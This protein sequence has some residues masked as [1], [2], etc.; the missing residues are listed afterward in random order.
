MWTTIIINTFAGIS[1]L[2]QFPQFIH[3]YSIRFVYFHC[4]CV[5][6]FIIIYCYCDSFLCVLCCVCFVRKKLFFPTSSWLLATTIQ[7]GNIE[8]KTPSYYK[9]I[10]GSNNNASLILWDDFFGRNVGARTMRKW[11][12]MGSQ[13]F[14][15]IAS[16][17]DGSKKLLLT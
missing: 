9:Q 1:K 5:L 11:N 10:N 2:V 14:M 3:R 15:L 4:R 16:V 13:R 12:K 8:N 6:T 17:L 7:R